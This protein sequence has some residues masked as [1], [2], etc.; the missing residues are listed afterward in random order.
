[1]KFK[2]FASMLTLVTS[3]G[4]T[5]LDDVAELSGIINTSEYNS[6]TKNIV[7]KKSV[8][9]M[10]IIVSKKESDIKSVDISIKDAIAN[11][12]KKEQSKSNN[13]KKGLETVFQTKERPKLK[14]DVK[15]KEPQ[16]TTFREEIGF[17]GSLDRVFELNYKNIAKKQRRFSRDLRRDKVLYL[18]FDDGPLRGTE[19]V[20]KILQEEGVDATMF[21]VGRHVLKRKEIFQREMQMQNLQLV[22]HTYSHA[23]GHYRRFYSNLYSV[24][25]DIEH[26]QLII[27]GTKFLRLAGR[28]VWRLPEV[29]RNDYGL[30]RAQWRAEVKDY[31][32]LAR[33]GF[34]IVGW[35]VEWGFNHKTGMP[36]CSAKTLAN[37]IERARRR[38]K[39]AKRGRAVLLTHDFMFRTKDS[40]RELRKFIRIMKNRGWKFK[41]IKHYVSIQPKPLRVAKYY[42]G[43]AKRVLA[44]NSTPTTTSSSTTSRQTT[45]ES[46][47]AKRVKRRGSLYSQLNEALKEYDAERVNH[48]LKMGVNPNRRDRYGRLALN[49][50]IKINSMGMV[51]KL[52]AHGARLNVRDKWGRTPMQTARRYKS[53]RIAR[54]LRRF[55]IAQRRLSKRARV[56]NKRVADMEK[57]R[58]K[59]ALSI[60]SS[61]I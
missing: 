49:T 47:K 10:E 37:R 60:L 3:V 12:L 15:D 5:S 30:P 18:T 50:A 17:F 31:N 48:I 20:L 36:T 35:D 25:S 23:N 11:I 41:K 8:P 43:N 39:L 29:R 22:N 44:L 58:A 54:Y 2:L 26:A 19:N 53:R 59:D 1:M 38:G 51:K 28:N 13:Q 16:E 24:M 55:Q 34:Y 40:S 4:A 6:E 27:G 32:T 61:R 14:I 52:I 56:A 57:K 9:G 7:I 46:P 42:K 45:K 21:C 33:N